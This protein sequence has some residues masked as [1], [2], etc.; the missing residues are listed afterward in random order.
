MAAVARA[1]DVDRVEVARRYH[2]LGGQPHLRQLPQEGAHAGH[3]LLAIRGELP[4]LKAMPELRDVK[5]SPLLFVAKALPASAPAFTPAR[6]EDL[7]QRIEHAQLLE[8]FG[9]R[10]GPLPRPPGSGRYRPA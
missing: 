8:R 2:G 9:A 7:R 5:V 4:R 3:L 10:G 6:V 1:H